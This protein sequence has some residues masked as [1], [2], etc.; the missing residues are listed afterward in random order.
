MGVRES[1][2]LL[3]CLQWH[4]EGCPEDDTSGPGLL[5]VQQGCDVERE[6][7]SGEVP[8]RVMN[9]S[10]DMAVQK[11]LDDRIGKKGLP[12]A[13][14]LGVPVGPPRQHQVQ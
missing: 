11:G 7:T 14:K 5:P 13:G 3:F 9:D 12:R 6:S 4:R 2:A 8:I 1:P 10:R